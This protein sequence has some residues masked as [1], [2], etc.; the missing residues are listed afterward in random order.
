MRD[1][2]LHI[3]DIVQNSVRADATL[4]NLTIEISGEVLI[5][6]I[7]DNGCGMTAETLQK[8]TDPFYTTRTT[9]KVG[10]GLPFFKQSAE[11]SGGELIIESE[12]G[13]GTVVTATFGLHH[14]DR[15][16]MGDLSETVSLVMSGNPLV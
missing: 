13:M 15:P 4:V 8:V 3:I 1:L 9:R 11:Q 5:I 10:L 12:V 7:G 16:P 14:L 6:R 2:S